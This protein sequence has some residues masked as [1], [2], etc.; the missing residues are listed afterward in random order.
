MVYYFKFRVPY[1][2]LHSIL[3]QRNYKRIIFYIDL[4]S[5][6]RG[7]YNADV[8]HLE[9]AQYMDS[10]TMPALFFDEAR[11]F[12][13]AI[14][15]QFKAYNPYFITFYDNGL[16]SQNKT[17]YKQYKGD[18]SKVIDN[19]MIEDAEKDLFRHIKN[20][21]FDQFIPRFTIPNLSNVIYMGDYEAD[22]TPHFII[23]NNLLN[24]QYND[25]LNVILSTDKDLLQTCEYENVIMCSTVYSKKEGT[26]NFNILDRYNAISYIYK[27]FKRGI[28]TAKYI[29]LILALSGDKADNISGIKSIGE[30]AAIKLIT[31]YQLPPIIYKSTPLPE[32]LELYRDQII[33]N[34]KLISFDEQL[35]RIPI[36]IINTAVSDGINHMLELLKK[37]N[38]II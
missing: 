11:V 6:T 28:L 12:Y 24:S 13:D 37:D 2:A 3:Q 20:Y 17:I 19:L 29:P 22:F 8:V 4:P 21:Y 27:N 33:T 38:D 10:K 25:V 18:R 1:T 31:Q 16:C 9:I 23:S 26:L 35:Q 30:A 34:L 14:L 36:T 32:K 15:N 5:I 7:F